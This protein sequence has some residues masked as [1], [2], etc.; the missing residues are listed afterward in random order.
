[1]ILSVKYQKA[2]VPVIISYNVKPR[3]FVKSNVWHFS[4]GRKKQHLVK[5]QHVQIIKVEVVRKH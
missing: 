2:A 4:R 1:M 3:Q 5:V